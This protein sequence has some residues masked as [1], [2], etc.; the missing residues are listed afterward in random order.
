[1]TAQALNARFGY[2]ELLQL[3]AEGFAI[4]FQSHRNLFDLACVV[5][6]WLLAPL[7]LA[8]STWARSTAARVSR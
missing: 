2:H 6:L 8:D 7:L 3:R 1:M 4:Y 5:S